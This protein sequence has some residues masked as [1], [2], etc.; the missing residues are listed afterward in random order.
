[1]LGHGYISPGDLDLIS[2]TDDVDEVVRILAA[3]DAARP[4]R[5]SPPPATGD[6]TPADDD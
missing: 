2:V 6:E 1:M 5:Q 4:D 3:A